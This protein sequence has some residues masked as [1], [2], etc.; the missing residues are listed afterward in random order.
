MCKSK[1]RHCVDENEKIY[2]IVILER[3]IGDTKQ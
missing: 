1:Y 3:A 2:C